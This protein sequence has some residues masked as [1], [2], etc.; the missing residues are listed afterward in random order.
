MDKRHKVRN[1]RQEGLT[2]REIA[3]KT[4]IPKST[5]HKLLQGSPYMDKTN[6]SASPPMD[7]V[8]HKVELAED[9]LRLIHLPYTYYCPNCG[10]EQNHVILCLECGKFLPAECVEDT[11]YSEG[12]DLGQV[13][14]GHQ[15]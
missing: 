3:Q 13:E 6:E 8:T 5:V 12:F 4:G 10:R 2:I 15:Q 1:L 7:K 11:C 14:R 9:S